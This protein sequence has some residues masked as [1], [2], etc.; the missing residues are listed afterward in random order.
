MFSTRKPFPS[1]ITADILLLEAKAA[2]ATRRFGA[3]DSIECI[4]GDNRSN[5]ALDLIRGAESRDQ[6]RSL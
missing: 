4:A 1:G 5:Q 3:G 2:A 6:F